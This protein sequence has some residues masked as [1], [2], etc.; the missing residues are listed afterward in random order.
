M[1]LALNNPEPRPCSCGPS[2]AKTTVVVSTTGAQSASHTTETRLHLLWL[3]LTV[4]AAFILMFRVRSRQNRGA[5]LFGIAVLTLVGAVLGT[6]LTVLVAYILWGGLGDGL[7]LRFVPVLL[8][9]VS[10]VMPVSVFIMAAGMPKVEELENKS[11]PQVE[12]VEMRGQGEGEE[13][14]ELLPRYRVDGEDVGDD[15]FPSPSSSQ[16][17]LPPPELNPHPPPEHERLAY[18]AGFEDGWHAYRERGP[19]ENSKRE[20]AAAANYAVAP[21][22]DHVDSTPPPYLDVRDELGEGDKLP[23]GNQ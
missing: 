1:L 20:E 16:P 10:V 22:S 6:G 2:F 18:A 13:R 15:A 7:R 23:Q 19:G 3:F 5:F 14:E 9:W 12:A 11:Y 17:P 4:V 21:N 8:R